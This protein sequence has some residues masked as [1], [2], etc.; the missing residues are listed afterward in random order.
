MRLTEGIV[1]LAAIKTSISC[2]FLLLLF[3]LVIFSLP[4]I[5]LVSSLNTEFSGD[6][7]GFLF[8]PILAFVW[9]YT[10]PVFINLVCKLCLIFLQGDGWLYVNPLWKTH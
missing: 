6:R 3:P 2:I 5:L 7:D 10:D 1:A 4:L 9:T 8:G